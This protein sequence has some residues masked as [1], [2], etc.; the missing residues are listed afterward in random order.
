MHKVTRLIYLQ[1]RGP[2]IMSAHLL[3]LKPSRR[4]IKEKGV[5]EQV[6]LNQLPSDIS[7]SEVGACKMN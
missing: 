5:T 3:N 2:I 1:T 4:E 7:H 6:S